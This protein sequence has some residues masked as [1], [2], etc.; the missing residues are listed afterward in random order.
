[1]PPLGNAVIGA[2]T[3]RIPRYAVATTHPHS[4]LKVILALVFGVIGIAGSFLIPLLG[5]VFGIAAIVLASLH[6]PA[7]GKLLRLTAFSV[8]CVA[9]LCGLAVWVMIASRNSTLRQQQGNGLVTSSGVSGSQVS[10]V[11]PCY[12]L[13]FSDQLT[14]S[15]QQGSCSMEAY[16]GTNFNDSSDVYKVL[17]TDVTNVTALN[18]DQLSK[19]AIENDVQNT[20]T[21]F[22]ITSEQAGQFAGSQAY[23]VKAYNAKDDVIAEE[24]AV[25][26]AGSAKQNYFVLVHATKGDSIDVSELESQWAW[27]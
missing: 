2:N 20:L 17:S 6:S 3:V 22:V 15:N 8:A 25:F 9:F 16:N 26:H 13:G 23:F 7:V 21:G 18:F 11:T 10:L 4:H 12:S 1:M 19:L 5:I 27:K 24:A 14:I